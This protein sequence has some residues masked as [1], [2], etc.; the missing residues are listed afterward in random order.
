MF[1]VILVRGYGENNKLIKMKSI[2][3]IIAIILIS[4]TNL[5]AQL[6]ECSSVL[7]YQQMQTFENA[8]YQNFINLDNLIANNISIQSQTNQ[9]LINPNGLITIPVVVHVLNCGEEIGTGRNIS[10]A[11]ILSQIAVLNEDFNRLN[12]NAINTPNA[13]LPVASNFGIEFRLACLD[14]NGNG[15]TGITRKNTT[16]S[17]YDPSHRMNLSGLPDED[18][19]G[20]KISSS[21]VP[22]WPTDKYLNIWV[23]NLL[24]G[25]SLGYSSFP[26]DFNLRP[27]FDGIVVDYKAFG[28]VGNLSASYQLGRTATHEI[29]HWLDLRHIWGDA[30]CGNDFILDTPPQEA[31]NFGCPNFPHLSNCTGNGTNGDMFMNYMDVSDDVCMN[32]FTNGQKSRARSLFLPSFLPR[33][34]ILENMFKLLPRPS[35]LYCNG[36]V[37]LQNLCCLPTTWSVISGNAT[38]VSS[39]ETEATISSTASG[40]IS[41]RVTAGNYISEQ[42]FLVSQESPE[43]AGIS[44]NNGIT[45]NNLVMWYNPS[46][47]TTTVNNVCIGFG[48]PNSYVEAVPF[49][50]SDNSVL[51]SSFNNLPQ[52]GFTLLQQSNNRGYFAFNYSTTTTGYLQCAVT[53]CGTNSRVVAFNQVNCNPGG[54][55]CDLYTGQKFFTISP[56]PASDQITIGVTNR[57]APVDCNS[58]KS[59]NTASGVCFSTV[60]IY[61]N[62]GTL[63]KSFKTNKSKSATIQISNLITGS[64]IVEIVEVDYLEKH[65]IMIQ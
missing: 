58:L 16:K 61:N 63:V 51:W 64:Y 53:G 30:N 65:Q 42:S 36:K 17:F 9:R 25:T 50:S 26:G 14:P 11:Q 15:T 5:K 59:L 6:R 7:D 18:K 49:G 33:F 29:G 3:I 47:P 35:T 19:I 44:Y 13:F 32:M 43:I 21:G 62:F 28:R 57:P 55:P 38:I 48:F 46:T 2:K 37:K 12:A 27:N 4:I 45:S 39:S 41:L 10:D 8:R 20:I 34:S 54:N 52:N 31:K 24:S 60:N 40:L 23:V 1:Q 22:A 56:N